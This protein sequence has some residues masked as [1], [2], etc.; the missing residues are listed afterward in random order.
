V[1]K[2]D[3]TLSCV[4]LNGGRDIFSSQLRLTYGTAHDLYSP[5]CTVCTQGRGN[6]GGRLCKARNTDTQRRRELAQHGVQL[7]PV[8]LRES[9]PTGVICAM[10]D[11]LYRLSRRTV[12]PALSG[13]AQLQTFFSYAE[14]KKEG[15]GAGPLLLC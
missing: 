10:M 4:F 6:E 11:S 1:C 13:A 14:G 3:S 8:K 2:L 12:P 15:E 7:G 9:G 5:C